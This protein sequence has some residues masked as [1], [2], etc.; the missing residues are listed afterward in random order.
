MERHHV[1]ERQADPLG[2]QVIRVGGEIDL[3][4]HDE[5]LD[6]IMRAV[7]TGASDILIDLHQ[8][9]L[10][11]SGAVGVLLAGHAAARRV[12]ARCRVLN[13]PEL[14]RRVLQVNGVLGLLTEG[15]PLDA[16]KP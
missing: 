4:A 11:D 3:T 15:R 10:F 7:H 9:T 6:A 12:P 8:V 5:L 2:V 14:V 13:P 1:I 16:A